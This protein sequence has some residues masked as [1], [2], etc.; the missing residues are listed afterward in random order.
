MAFSLL[1]LT[2]CYYKKKSFGFQCFSLYIKQARRNG[3]NSGG[4][5]RLLKNAGQL[6]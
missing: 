6:G 4:A 5:G 1:K 3:K 2:I